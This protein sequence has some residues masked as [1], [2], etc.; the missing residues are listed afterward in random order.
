MYQEADMWQEA[1]RLAQLHL[2]HRV[3]E[4]N[5]AY[6]SNQARAGKGSHKNDYISTGRSFEQAQKW[7]QAVDAYLSATRDKIDSATELEDIWERAIEVARNRIPNR[8]VEIALEVSRRLV[9][10]QREESAAD[11]LF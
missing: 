5:Q 10:I 6:Q 4:V 7:S 9:E 2:P 3:A 1:L 11:I 8:H